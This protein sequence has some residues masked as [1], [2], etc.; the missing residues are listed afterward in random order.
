MHAPYLRGESF[1]IVAFKARNLNRGHIKYDLNAFEAR[2]FQLKAFPMGSTFFFAKIGW[3][4]FELYI[5]W[6][7]TGK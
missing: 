7:L 3:S 4:V 5:A 1:D 6:A 2:F